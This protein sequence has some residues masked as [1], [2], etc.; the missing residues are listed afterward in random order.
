MALPAGRFACLDA[1]QALP[2]RHAKLDPQQP[3]QVHRNEFAP[4]LF[5]GQVQ[6]I[7]IMLALQVMQSHS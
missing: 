5:A 4:V 3:A 7:S 2:E 1:Q 6:S